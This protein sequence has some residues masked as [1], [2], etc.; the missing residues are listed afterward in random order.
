MKTIDQAMAARKARLTLL[1]PV[2]AASAAALA[3]W[4]DVELTYSSNAIEGNTLTRIETAVVLEKGITVSG[5]PLRDHLE[6]VGHKDALDYV[7]QLARENEP[8]R[9][10]DI[11]RLHELVMVR[12]D[13]VEAGKYSDHQRL[14]GGSQVVLPPAHEIAPL[15]ADFAS[16]LQAAKPSAETAFA[17]HAKFET[18]HPFSDGN[19]RTGRLLMNLLLMKSG[20]PPVVIGP[21]HRVAYLEGL[22]TLQLRNDLLP[23][24]QFMAER[25]AVSLDHHIEVLSRS[26]KQSPTSTSPL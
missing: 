21:E 7:R 14:I 13:P 2:T 25:L 15:M 8:I 11:R 18:I 20:Y 26:Q 23:Y 5:K 10:I 4:Y 16:W 24:R 1:R 17:A 9:E 12:V 22:E 3:H 19:G 6:A